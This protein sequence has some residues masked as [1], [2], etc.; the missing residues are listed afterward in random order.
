VSR[1]TSSF[2]RFLFGGAKLGCRGQ[3]SS[4]HLLEASH[5]LQNI[6]LMW[7]SQMPENGGLDLSNWKC[8]IEVEL[9]NLSSL[10]HSFARF[11]LSPF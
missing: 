9:V 2:A 7:F 8:W 4:I 5:V 3:Q 10:E 6:Q 1:L 11:L